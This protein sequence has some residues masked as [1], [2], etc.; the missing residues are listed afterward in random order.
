VALG[1]DVDMSDLVSPRYIGS[2]KGSSS[3]ELQLAANEIGLSA[4]PLFGLGKYSLK[5]VKDPLILHVSPRGTDGS[6][7]HWLLFLGM[8]NGNSIV[9]DGPGGIV[10]C[11]IEHVFA[12]WDGTAIAIRRPGSPSTGYFSEE[13]GWFSLLLVCVILAIAASQQYLLGSVE[14]LVP[15]FAAES[16]LIG[17]ISIGFA[18]G[19][20][21]ANGAGDGG[22]NARASIDSAAGLRVYPSVDTTELISLVKNDAILVIDCRY[23]KDFDAG[24]IPSSVNLP[25]DAGM[26]ELKSFSDSITKTRRIV[27]FCQSESCHFSELVATLLSAEGFG[28]IQIFRGGYNA[29]KE[30]VGAVNHAK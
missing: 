15:R 23:R 20:Y 18:L 25:V 7:V 29:W 12:R 19:S 17:L 30:I 26:G 2:S 6:Y 14:R 5:N 24:T 10:Q 9:Y 3:A 11:S 28:N 8:E 16:F 21:A 1:A 13:F 22:K 4:T 27:L